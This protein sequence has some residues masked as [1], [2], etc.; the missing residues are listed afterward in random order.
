LQRLLLQVNI[1][2]PR[3]SVKEFLFESCETLGRFIL[4]R[5]GNRFIDDEA[6]S[7]S[8]DALRILEWTG[9]IVRAVIESKAREKISLP[10]AD[11]DLSSIRNEPSFIMSPQQSTITKAS[12]ISDGEDAS[13]N[14][15]NDCEPQAMAYTLVASSC[16]LISE[17]LA[18][19]GPG[20]VAFAEKACEWCSAVP[21][22]GLLLP[23]CRLAIQLV[24][25]G[26]DCSLLKSITRHYKGGLEEA[27]TEII[28][29]TFSFVLSSVV[30]QVMQAAVLA[31]TVGPPT[32]FDWTDDMACSAESI[33]PFEDSSSNTAL[34]AAIGA[35]LR[36]AKASQELVHQ[37]TTRLTNMQQ[38]HQENGDNNSNGYET[39]LCFLVHCLGMLSRSGSKAR[40]E[41][42][43]AISTLVKTLHLPN[44][45][46]ETLEEF[47]D[48][49]QH[50][51]VAAG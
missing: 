27:A 36:S 19:G 12:R 43:A 37:L 33:L 1:A 13:L 5:E 30:E 42:S 15:S 4:H 24:K 21:V 50:Q 3:G 49:I 40:E 22:P 25:Q 41:A 17:W 2:V 39:V 32:T 34:K 16:I 31:C 45:A 6:Q 7:L 44:P 35:I 9:N 18:V 10:F 47:W 11:P 51:T 46:G 14:E 28:H 23:F 29:N 8:P 26:N 20:V 38:Q 48:Q